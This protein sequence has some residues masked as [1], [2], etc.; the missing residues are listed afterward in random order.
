LGSQLA[1][2]LS[3]LHKKSEEISELRAQV[4]TLRRMTT[5]GDA[6]IVYTQADQPRNSW[7]G[8]DYRVAEVQ[9]DHEPEADTTLDSE[10]ARWTQ[11]KSALR[12]EVDALRGDKT[13]A[14]GDVNFF[15]EQYQRA[16]DFASS[17][18]SENEE[19]SARAA[20]AESQAVNGVALVRATLEVRVTKLEAEARKYKAL[21]EMLTE[22][23]RRTDDDVRF[24]AALMPELERE[25][26]QLSRQYREAEAELEETQDELRAQKR[27][28]VRLRRQVASL[29]TKERSDAAESS[30]KR[31]PVPW[32]DDDESDEDYRPGS[33][34]S[35]PGSPKGNNDGS[36]PQHQG[37]HHDSPPPN[38]DDAQPAGADLEVEQSTSVG[39]DA[40]L[41]SSSADM[42]YLCRWRP[43]DLAGYCDAV[44]ASKQ[45]KTSTRPACGD[46][47]LTPY[48]NCTS[49]WRR[50]IFPAIKPSPMS[51]VCFL[52]RGGIAASHSPSLYW[53][54]KSCAVTTTP[55]PDS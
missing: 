3:L 1:A 10:R 13:R 22:R 26:R 51:I 34:P 20:L 12:D 39:L 49:T 21:S 45:V 50:T 30:R 53:A 7:E 19:L 2:A 8:T 47:M 32:S 25:L 41:Q 27:A 43:G 46:S 24:R 9:T 15:R 37:S 23:S 35:A 6:N 18:R 31:E 36:S 44:V 11:E 40:S 54:L 17:T 48:R 38:E 5:H 33:G 42:V 14:L 55:I 52:L 4:N 29:E 28:N 16:S